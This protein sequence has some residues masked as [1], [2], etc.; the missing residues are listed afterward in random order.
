MTSQNRVKPWAYLEILYVSNAFTFKSKTSGSIIVVK[1]CFPKN[2]QPSEIA[3]SLPDSRL[4]K[5]LLGKS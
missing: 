5:L 3:F 4:K 1:R 2:L